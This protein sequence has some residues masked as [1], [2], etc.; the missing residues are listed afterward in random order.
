[1]IENDNIEQSQSNYCVTTAYPP[2]NGQFILINS[3]T[4]LKTLI[5]LCNYTEGYG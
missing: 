1:M 4:Y 2:D 5:D 3:E